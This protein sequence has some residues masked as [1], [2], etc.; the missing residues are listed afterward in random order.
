MLR[1]DKGTYLSLPFKLILSEILSL[2]R[3]DVLLFSELEK[4]VFIPFYN[5]IE[6]ATLLYTFLVICFA[7]CKEYIIWRIS[8]SNFSYVLPAFTCA[9][10]NGNLWSICLEVNTLSSFSFCWFLKSRIFSATLIIFFNFCFQEF[11]L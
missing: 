7:Q 1:F 2:W 4:I 9:S 3:S 10:A 6:F 8:F 11:L 5:F